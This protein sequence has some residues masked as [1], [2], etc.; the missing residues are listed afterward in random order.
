MNQ[1]EKNVP[2]T[3]GDEPDH[4]AAQHQD[5]LL[6]KEATLIRLYELHLLV[7][8]CSDYTNLNEIDVEGLACACGLFTEYKQLIQPKVKHAGTEI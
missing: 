6:L 8:A 5:M 3:R 4:Q 2:H 1:L 7:D